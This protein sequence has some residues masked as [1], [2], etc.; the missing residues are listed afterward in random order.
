[1]I[2]PS[3][4]YR[5]GQAATVFP[6]DYKVIGDRPIA[7][8][9]W[10]AD[11]PVGRTSVLAY[12]GDAWTGKLLGELAPSFRRVSWL[13]SN[14]GDAEM[15]F[16]SDDPAIGRG[17]LRA[18]NRVLLL[19]DN[20]LPPWA[21]IIDLPIQHGRSQI[22][23][24]AYQL[25]HALKYR[26]TDRHFSGAMT[27]R[28]FAEDLIGQ[29]NVEHPTGLVLEPAA[30][31]LEQEIEVDFHMAR[32]WDAFS[33][34]LEPYAEWIDIGYLHP[35]HGIQSRIILAERIGRDLTRHVELIG[36]I[37]MREPDIVEQGP[38]YNQWSLSSSSGPWDPYAT[39]SRTVITERDPEG[40]PQH[41]LR[42]THESV[43]I[44][45]ETA[46]RQLAQAKIA[47][48]RMPYVAVSGTV[49][50]RP[51]APFGS[52]GPGDTISATVLDGRRQPVTYHKRVVGIEL[53]P[54]SGT[55][56]VIL[57]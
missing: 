37:N 46:M 54:Q 4:Y 36:G 29:A 14:Y 13:L 18:G 39:G 43:D 1:M 48:A 20:G 2:A 16:M 19:F 45:T 25:P 30:G 28:Q 27:V 42:A 41:G 23:I 15:Q 34:T 51:P 22:T 40:F 49:I 53:Y 6:V 57:K 35:A 55:C 38:V 21:G 17:L 9:T 10:V 5:A 8:R 50:D 56:E 11:T 32:A 33:K 26:I 12:V 47:N 52:Y 31:Q 24:R 3:A 7:R 44:T